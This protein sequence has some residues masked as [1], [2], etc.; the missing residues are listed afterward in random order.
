LANFLYA[1]QSTGEASYRLV[2]LGEA[3]HF[4]GQ[5]LLVTQWH[6]FAIILGFVLLVAGSWLFVSRLHSYYLWQ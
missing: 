1:A 3:I 2:A 6:P 5:R 4:A